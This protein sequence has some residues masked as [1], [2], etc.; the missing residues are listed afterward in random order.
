MTTSSRR[1]FLGGLGGGMLALGLGERAFALGWPEG[2][3][4]DTLQA[5]TFG[6]LEPWVALMQETEPEA[7]QELL[8]GKLQ[9]G[10]PLET[11]VSA[12]ALANARSFGGH[13]YIGYHCMMALM[14]AYAMAKRLPAA[15]APLPV[16]KVLY[17]NAARIQATGGRPEEALRALPKAGELGRVE[18][19]ERLRKAFL[20][21]D[22]EGAEKAFADLA[23]GKTM[24]A[25]ESLQ[26]LLRDD[27]NVHRVVLTWRAWETAQ[28]A[29]EQY[30][31]TLLRQTIRYCIDEEELRLDRGRPEP[32][33]RTLVPELLESC[34]L[35]SKPAGTRTAS[36]DELLELSRVV[37]CSD[38]ADAARAMA[39]ALSEGLSHRDAGEA[40]SLAANWLMLHDP[41]RSRDEGSEKPKGSVHGAST[42]VHAADAARAWRHIAAVLS[43]PDAAASLIAGA[44]HTA[45]Q[46][47]Y[48]AK[49]PV[50]YGNREDEVRVDDAQ[51]LVARMRAAVESGDQMLAC[52]AAQVYLDQGFPEQGLFDAL[53]EYAL[54]QDG[55]LHAEKYFHTMTEEFADARPAFRRRHLVALARVTASE[56]GWPAPGYA[57]AREQLGV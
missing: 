22:I 18:S 53:L 41:G 24:E 57:A 23:R 21:R 36:D 14:P 6:E 38:R 46:S 35:A 2:V 37:F 15:S 4:D 49:R 9:A 11:L 32:E 16:L 44:F 51:E 27:I 52:A 25:Y 31:P 43:A 33:L 20:E 3:D 19:E 54:S 34:G 47:G 17:R 42:G 10:L 40:I 28:F 55:A 8:I 45:G 56:H 30:A 29:G 7:L 13:D 1:A 50:D 26:T 5:L 48:V 12:G 39:Q